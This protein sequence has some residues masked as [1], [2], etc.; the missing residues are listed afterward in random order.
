MCKDESFPFEDEDVLTFNNNPTVI[1]KIRFR[2][3]NIIHKSD[4]K[5]DE[6]ELEHLKMLIE[7]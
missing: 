4:L 1:D 5:F 6:A 3:S 2:I 7:N